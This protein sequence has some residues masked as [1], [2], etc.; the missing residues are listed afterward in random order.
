MAAGSILF[1]LFSSYAFKSVADYAVSKLGKSAFQK[2]LEADFERWAERLP[3]GLGPVTLEAFFKP[4]PHADSGPAQL[5]V[6]GRFADRLIPSVQQLQ[7]ALLEQWTRI[8]RSAPGSKLVPFFRLDAADAAPHLAELA[9]LLQLACANEQEMFQRT[10]FEEIEAKKA[11][12]SGANHAVEIKLALEKLWTKEFRQVGG[13]LLGK[14][15]FHF[16]DLDKKTKFELLRG[17]AFFHVLQMD[18]PESARRFRDA[19]RQAPTEARGKAC[20]VRA[21]ISEER[22][23]EAQE[24]VLSLVK[25]F[26]DDLEIWALRIL[27]YKD[28]ETADDLAGQGPAGALL[29]AK[30]LHGLGKVALTNGD[31]PKAYDYALK[32]RDAGHRLVT[33]YLTLGNALLDEY[34]LPEPWPTAPTVN[35]EESA[36]RLR[37]AIDHFDEGLRHSI[38]APWEEPTIEQIAANKADALTWLGDPGVGDWLRSA[39]E[40]LPNSQVIRR[41]YALWLSN[42]EALNEGIE[43]LRGVAQATQSPQARHELGVLLERR[44]DTK[45]LE[46]ASAAALQVLAEP[47][48]LEPWLRAAALRLAVTTLLKLGKIEQASDVLDAAKDDM[49]HEVALLGLDLAKARGG[50]DA[51]RSAALEAAD[52]LVGQLDPQDATTLVVRLA[53]AEE[54]AAAKKVIDGVAEDERTELLDRYAVYCTARLGNETETLRL[55]RAYRKSHGFNEDVLHTE[56]DALEGDPCGAADLMTAYLREKPE[57]R[58]VW[59]R[60][61][62]LGVRYARPEWVATDLEKLPVA[63]TCNPQNGRVAAQVLATAGEPDRALRYA[64]RLFRAHFE[65]GDAREALRDVIYKFSERPSLPQPDVVAPDCAVTLRAEYG[66]EFNVVLES[67]DNPVQY[68]DEYPPDA[69]LAKAV[70]GK[71]AG[72]AVTLPSIGAGVRTARITSIQDKHVFWAQKISQ[73]TPLISPVAGAMRVIPIGKTPE[74]MLASVHSMLSENRDDTASIMSAY[75]GESPLSVHGIA[76]RLGKTTFEAVLQLFADSDEILRTPGENP[77]QGASILSQGVALDDTALATL[78]F[79][80]ANQ[81][82]P[83]TTRRICLGPRLCAEMRRLPSVTRLHREHSQV[84]LD[85]A[86]EI[87]MT[88]VSDEQRATARENAEALSAWVAGSCEE[89]AAVWE[90]IELAPRR[91]LQE[92]FGPNGLEALAVARTQGLPLAT[93]DLGLAMLARTVG[94]NVISSLDL[95]RLYGQAGLLSAGAVR[96]KKLLLAGAGYLGTSLKAVDAVWAGNT[97][98][99]EATSQPLRDCFRFLFNRHISVDGRIPMAL[100]LIRGAFQ[101]GVPDDR[102]ESVVAT[103]LWSADVLGVGDNSFTALVNMARSTLDGNNQAVLDTIVARRQE[104]VR[105]QTRS[106]L[107]LARQ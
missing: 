70:L 50:K 34:G 22:L 52:T 61:S 60:R 30:V 73:P 20:I 29:E 54:F 51:E 23:A 62:W 57:D 28:G 65:S 9:R 47:A 41:G 16:D 53:E 13:V 93:D 12:S 31:R 71:R 58:L 106:G 15:R 107:I 83:R 100:A 84:S 18:G 24:E 5:E 45:S 99:W 74:E 77:A 59:L 90:E 72:E 105:S 68:R 39:R 42:N 56:L 88:A 86:G 26:P 44:G 40:M 66:V 69:E 17:V 76:E 2:R 48:Q 82:L 25:E 63:E 35:D 27:L 92:V 33:N 91:Q 36:K 87:V 55:A 3:D 104:V 8:A 101:E 102:R 4:H 11:D 79:I 67:G 78:V 43:L 14:L 96:G 19:A 6:Y 49:A 10:V 95:L 85:A 64:F 94:V 46:G 7:A 89:T 103:A 75:R 98:E 97:S 81:I 80:E 1:G 21:F 37:N 38:G 32:A